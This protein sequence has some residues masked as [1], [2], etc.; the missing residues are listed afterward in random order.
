MAV[1]GQAAEHAAACARHTYP[2]ADDQLRFE[3]LLLVGHLHNGAV[4]QAAARQRRQRARQQRPV[5]GDLRVAGEAPVC[6]VLW[7]N[8][9]Q[10]CS[11]ASGWPQLGMQTQ[12]GLRGARKAAPSSKPAGGRVPI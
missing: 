5:E 8:G 12:G 3:L 4:H 10:P 7:D 1:P 11:L 2:V 9:M 6:V